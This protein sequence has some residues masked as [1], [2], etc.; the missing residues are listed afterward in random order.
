MMMGGNFGW[1]GRW[2]FLGGLMMLLFWG[3]LIALIVLAIRGLIP[4][5]T[6]NRSE[7]SSQRNGATQSPLEILQIRYAKGEISREDYELIRRD[8]QTA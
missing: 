2:V 7:P 3:G 6:Q 1:G 5:Y 8:L 4:R